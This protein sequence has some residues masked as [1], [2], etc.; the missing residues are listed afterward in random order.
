VLRVFPR[1]AGW[2][3]DSAATAFGAFGPA[4][5][6]GP[7]VARVLAPIL[8]ATIFWADRTAPPAV[9]VAALYVAPALL[10]IRTG[11]FWE[12][13][14]VAVVATALTFVADAPPLSAA[15]V[16][17]SGL[18][19]LVQVLVIWLS[20]GAVAYHRRSSDRWTKRIAHEQDSLRGTIARLEQLRHALDAA[21]IV[22]VTDQRGII[23]DVNDKFCEISKY[24]REEL[25]GQDHRI[26][27]SGYHPAEFMRELWRTIARGR[28]WRG[29]IC[30]RAKDGS[31]YWVDTTIVPFCDARGKPRQYLAIR[32]EITQRKAAEARLAEQAALAQLGELAAVV[33]HEVRNPLAGLRGALE[34]LRP[35]LGD[36]RPERDV[37]QA[38]IDR[39]DVLNA[40]VN[41]I[42]RFAR[43]QAPSLAAVHLEPLCREAVQSAR[44]AIGGAAPELVL[45]VEPLAVHGDAEMLRAALLNLLLNACQSGADRIE[46]TASASGG[47]CRIAVRD[48]G[49]GIP[50]DVAA[51]VFEAFYTTKKSGTG[52]GLPIVKRLTELQGGRVSL[53]ARE[54][55][56]TVAELT[57]PRHAESAVDPRRALA[58]A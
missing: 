8:L 57:F 4:A 26:V 51:R 55:G 49:S 42:L 22:A 12:P 25:L 32:S 47:E 29:E 21:A 34:V 35:R 45:A 43:P 40:K 23:T 38:M 16:D 30:N 48:N 56:G 9:D 46:V 20:A 10:F 1:L 52:L 53:R 7:A 19:W 54:G 17:A 3:H 18:R 6:R 31:F 14:I 5:A 28:V 24:S 44:A 2:A 13:V 39:I 50:Q 15:G 27:N 36:G 33:A 37:V 11:R 41:D 58:P